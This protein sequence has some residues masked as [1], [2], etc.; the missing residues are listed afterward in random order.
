MIHSTRV[1][2]PWHFGVDPDPGSGS[3]Y[4]CHWPSRFQQKTNFLTQFFCL[5]FFE[6][7]FT[8]FFKDKKSKKSHKIINSRFFLLFLHDD[9]RIRIRESK[10]HVDPVD[11][12]HCTVLLYIPWD[13]RQWR[14]RHPS[15]GSRCSRTWSWSDGSSGSAGLATGLKITKK[16]IQNRY[17]CRSMFKEKNANKHKLPGYTVNGQRKIWGSSCNYGIM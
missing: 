6:G 5:L 11:P 9:R 3:C 13:C 12:K 14:A 10:K 8:S 1:P 17:W 2:D 16:I 15:A 4:F 7:T